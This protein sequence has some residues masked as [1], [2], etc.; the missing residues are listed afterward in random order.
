M[1]NNSDF[2]LLERNKLLIKPHEII[3]HVKKKERLSG[4]GMTPYTFS[5]SFKGDMINNPIQPRKL[6]HLAKDMA[7][8]IDKKGGQILIALDRG[9]TAL[10]CIG[11]LIISPLNE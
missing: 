2:K 1:K 8:F 9:G 4:L 11:L 6:I 3:I 10:G 5:Y 7:K